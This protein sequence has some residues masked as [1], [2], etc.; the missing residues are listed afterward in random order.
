MLA[1]RRCRERASQ[2]GGDHAYGAWGRDVSDAMVENPTSRDTLSL[3]A[4]ERRATLCRV[5]NALAVLRERR[6]QISRW[7][8]SDSA[9]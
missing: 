2:E 9:S 3:G 7:E 8:T 1:L 6:R 5:R 4:T